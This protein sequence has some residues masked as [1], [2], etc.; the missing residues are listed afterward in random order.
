MLARSEELCTTSRHHRVQP[1][2]PPF[3]RATRLA[4]PRWLSNP[5]KHRSK[6]PIGSVLYPWI[7][8]V[9][10]RISRNL[11]LLH[12]RVDGLFDLHKILCTQRKPA[13]IRFNPIQP[14]RP[15]WEE[16]SILFMT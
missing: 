8:H 16:K 15:F 10:R 3:R 2:A 4:A 9:S 13:K 14:S 6:T 12:T 5:R 7:Q 1:P 11:H